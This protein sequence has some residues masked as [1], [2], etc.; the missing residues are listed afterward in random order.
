M[1]KSMRDMKKWLAGM[2][3]V[4]V[5]AGTSACGGQET[6]QQQTATAETMAES[7]AD[8]TTVAEPAP[9]EEKALTLE[10]LKEKNG[11]TLR[12]VQND[13][14]NITFLKGEFYDG[15]IKTSKDAAGALEGVLGLLGGDEETR[16]KAA[17]VIEDD[18]GYHYFSFYQWHG[19]TAVQY[20][21][22]KVIT[23]PDGKA[24]ALTSSLTPGISGDMELL[25]SK[26][27]AVK[28]VREKLA[29]DDAEHQYEFYTDYVGKTT[30]AKEVR[31]D[32]ETYNY[33]VYIVY[34]SNPKIDMATT[35]FPYLAHYV[36]GEGTYLHSM[37]V[38]SIEDPAA[39]KG[40]DTEKYF[41][42]M[43]T[44]EYTETITLLNGTQREITVPVMKDADGTYYLADP[45]RKIA[46]ADC[47][48]FEFNDRNVAMVSSDHNGG[49][50]REHL[51]TYDNYIK[52]Y[53]F[54]NEAGWPS[55]DGYGTP[56]L[57]LADYCD[58]DRE[59]IQNACYQGKRDGW[60]T[61][62]AA[63]IQNYC[64]AM[65]LNAHEYTHGFT[66]TSMTGI[67]YENE[68][69]AIN[70]AMSDIMGNI[71]EMMAGR[72]DDTEWNIAENSEE[73]M[74]CMTDPHKFNQPA[75]VGDAYY[76]PSID[77]PSEGNDKGGVHANNSLLA[78]AA[79]K[80][81]D[82]GMSLEEERLLWTTFICF[83]VPRSGYKEA[84]EILDMAAEI[85]G[86][87][88][89]REKIAKVYSE[90]RLD[91]IDS[92]DQEMQKGCGRL[93]V[94]LKDVN[95]DKSYIIVYENVSTGHMGMA[96]A[97]AG[98]DNKIICTVEP[99]DYTFMIQEKEPDSGETVRRFVYIQNGWREGKPDEREKVTIQDGQIMETEA[100][101]TVK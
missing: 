56:I 19:E 89:Y 45:E 83:L 57:I 65:D 49:W 76:L 39:D 22:L 5:V 69:G 91:R 62:S 66:T 70:E 24:V 67:L 12:Y 21:V 2:L 26:E 77:Q 6:A 7:S 14:G 61:F 68:Y 13:E 64:D 96:Y 84:G 15:I 23:D 17:D 38:L 54:Y 9:E 33:L 4:T 52:S 79:P 3:A 97:G 98:M 50:K 92:W 51:A 82:R 95:E 47:W 10:D 27:D 20:S 43:T 44:E 73:A 71:A 25:I 42:N 28:I 34:T 37:P 48:E 41:E 100:L 36:S 94:Q 101:I 88:A 87:S 40:Y 29:K 46:M 85:S 8:Q 93:N 81:F 90:I 18:N 63:S 59:P 75:F 86:L 11:D 74:R 60:Q 72:T 31:E 1:K 53:D 32:E 58:Q 80:L 99:G 35:D 16:I 30:I 55:V 78:G